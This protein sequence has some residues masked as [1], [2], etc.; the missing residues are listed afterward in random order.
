MLLCGVDGYILAGK[1]PTANRSAAFASASD[2]F[3]KAYRD[4]GSIK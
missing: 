4:P 2:R 3:I 1:L